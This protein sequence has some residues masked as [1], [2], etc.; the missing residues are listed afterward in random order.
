M[1]RTPLY[2]VCRQPWSRKGPPSSMIYCDVCRDWFHRLCERLTETEFENA[3][4]TDLY[5][6]RACTDRGNDLWQRLLATCELREAAEAGSDKLQAELGRHVVANQSDVSSVLL[7]L[8]TVFHDIVTQCRYPHITDCKSMTHL[9][10][11]CFAA[12]LVAHCAPDS[13]CTQ[14]T[15]RFG[16]FLLEQSKQHG[17]PST[18]EV[19]CVIAEIVTHRVG[20]GRRFLTLWKGYDLADSS[21]EHPKE[22]NRYGIT[23]GRADHGLPTLDASSPTYAKDVEC[24]Y[25]R[26]REGFGPCLRP[27]RKEFFPTEEAKQLAD[28]EDE[29]FKVRQQLALTARR[30]TSPVALQFTSKPKPLPKK[31]ARSSS[32]SSNSSRSSSSS[33]SVIEINSSDSCTSE[34][35]A[36][37]KVV[38]RSKLE[39]KPAAKRGRKPKE[40][41]GIIELKYGTT[42]RNGMRVCIFLH[43]DWH[44]ATITSKAGYAKYS[45][46][47]D[48]KKSGL[49]PELYLRWPR[50]VDKPG[51]RVTDGAWYFTEQPLAPEARSHP[52][53]TEAAPEPSKPKRTSLKA[54]RSAS[55]LQ[56]PYHSDTDCTVVRAEQ[57]QETL[58]QVPPPSSLPSL[59]DFL[60]RETDDRL[61]R[62]FPA[63]EPV[64][65][66]L[67]PHQAALETS[68]KYL[69]RHFLAVADKLCD[70]FICPGSSGSISPEVSSPREIIVVDGTRDERLAA[71]KAEARALVSAASDTLLAAKVIALLVSDSFGGS[72]PAVLLQCEEAVHSC[73]TQPVLLC[74]V[75]SGSCRYRAILFKYLADFVGLP[76]TLQR[77]YLDKDT[78]HAWNFVYV[79]TEGFL[80]DTLAS[81]SVFRSLRDPAALA[82]YTDFS[83]R[84]LQAHLGEV[85]ENLALS[86]RGAVVRE[87]VIAAGRF[88]RVY[89]ANVGGARVACKVWNLAD[90]RLLEAE[91]RI[92]QHARHAHVVRYLG[93]HVSD[94]TSEIEILMEL[95]QSLIHRFQESVPLTPAAVITIGLHIASALKYLHALRIPGARYAGVLH[96]DVKPDNILVFEPCNGQLIAKLT[97]FGEARIFE[98]ANFASENS[99]TEWY[100]APEISAQGDN[101]YDAKV[102]VWS[103]GRTLLQA[104]YH[105][106][107][108]G[109]K[110]KVGGALCDHEVMETSLQCGQP[111]TTTCLQPVLDAFRGSGIGTLFTDLLL[112]CQCVRPTGRPTSEELVVTLDKL[113]AQYQ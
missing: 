1:S 34:T 65:L 70:G 13:K 96:R 21:W 98:T 30:R 80:V 9:F 61:A 58:S 100:M 92:L 77:G 32:R 12:R 15:A 63:P 10:Q 31:R 73:Y 42:L 28:A 85:F 22:L 56:V 24:V 43:G 110:L 20:T 25:N 104:T 71:L 111:L 72:N 50:W 99:G 93:H 35:L 6:C 64:K 107:A 103:L 86:V 40:L 74:S 75:R 18:W 78:L 4:K 109:T 8:F 101:Q 83:H 76:S 60:K 57:E 106:A 54:Q 45:L 27:R 90:L 19:S 53:A 81:S 14:W 66:D 62:L 88:A 48:S 2:C 17:D 102:D 113:R 38:P 16:E 97:D 89:S 3:R 55:G 46:A 36:K 41:T 23:F 26:W 108:P 87:R 91:L 84:R 52:R 68:K 37:Q 7:P 105:A 95:S 112:K 82:S 47:W 5:L 94:A 51:C 69:S 49:P 33:S 11:K 59:E 29:L 44:T 79:G 39:G 67:K